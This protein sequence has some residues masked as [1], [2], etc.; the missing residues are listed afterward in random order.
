MHCR[1]TGFVL[2]AML[3]LASFSGLAQH[4]HEHEAAAAAGPLLA[5][6]EKWATDAPLRSGMEQI[7][8][9]VAVPQATVVAGSALTPADAR[10]LAEGVRYQVDELIRNC[11]LEPAADAALHLLI[12][13]M[14]Q[15]LDELA[16]EPP[17]V[18]GLARIQ[19]AIRQ[20]PRYFSHPGWEAGGIDEPAALAARFQ[21]ELA[22]KLQ[23]AMQAGGPVNAIAV[24]RD[25]APAIASRLSRQ[26]GWQLRRVGTRVRNPL[27]G[28]PDAWEQQQLAQF[29]QRLQSGEAAGQIDK[30]ATVDGPGGPVVRYMQAIVVAPPCLACHGEP[31]TQPEA[32]RAA[33]ARDYPHDAATGYAAGELRGAFSLQR[34]RQAP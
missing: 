31:A 4:E 1:K 33:L 10:Q 6:G 11:K 21:Q 7:R 5:P 30:L 18:L 14:L 3:L 24:C 25:E 15:G 13:D 29:Q 9:L 23:A 26:S 2:A 17:S 8:R 34:P 20:Y 12:A 28:M 32:L 27:T 19:N 22:G 16:G